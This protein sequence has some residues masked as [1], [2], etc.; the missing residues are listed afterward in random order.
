M[1][2]SKLSRIELRAQENRG[3]QMD[4]C[5]NITV[6]LNDFQ[7]HNLEYLIE[8]VRRQ[9]QSWVESRRMNNDIDPNALE[10][11]WEKIR[12]EGFS[13]AYETQ[14]G[15]AAQAREMGLFADAKKAE[16]RL[17]KFKKVFHSAAEVGNLATY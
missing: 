15:L 10:P 5:R 9:A 17:K 13:H 7:N 1:I 11:A 6:Y 3:D 12:Q 14:K 4:S 16:E 8:G 2:V